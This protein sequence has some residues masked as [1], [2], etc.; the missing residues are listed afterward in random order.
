MIRR[1]NIKK[2]GELLRTAEHMF[3]YRWEAG[4][5]EGD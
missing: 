3:A 5:S 2:A 4:R 1:D